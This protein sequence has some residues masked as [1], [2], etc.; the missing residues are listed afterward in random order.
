MT[1]ELTT[2]ITGDA[3]GVGK[4]LDAFADSLAD[5]AHTLTFTTHGPVF[6]LPGGY[7]SRCWPRTLSCRACS[8]GSRP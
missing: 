7:W 5:F 2:R 1:V 6:D 4:S 8:S 3:G